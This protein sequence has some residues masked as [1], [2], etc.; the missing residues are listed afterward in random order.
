MELYEVVQ[1][2][3]NTRKAMYL[4]W[5]STAFE[6]IHRVREEAGTSN[7]LENKKHGEC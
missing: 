1:F 5:A 4:F 3:G 7:G 2:N 6:A